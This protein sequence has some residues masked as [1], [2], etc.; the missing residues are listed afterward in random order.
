[1]L[2]IIFKIVMPAGLVIALAACLIAIDRLTD[3]CRFYAVRIQELTW[4]LEDA[5]KRKKAR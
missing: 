3:R 2:E 1:M 4:E 5:R